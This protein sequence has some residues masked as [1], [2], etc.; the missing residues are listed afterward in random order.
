MTTISHW[1]ELQQKF[2][3]FLGEKGYEATSVNMYKSTVKMLIRYANAH[4]YAEYTP[5]IG[6]EFIKS[7]ERLDYLPF[8]G[9]RSR[10]N[11]IR[12]LDEFLDGGKYTYAHLRMEYN[13]P[14]AFSSE[15]I[16]FL[17]QLQ[18]YGIK[19]RTIA[20]YRAYLIRLFQDF[21]HNGINRWEDVGAKALT[22]AFER[23]TS[24][25]LFAAYSKRL[26]RYLISTGVVKY[27]YS[28]ILPK[29][30]YQKKIPSVYSNS[31]VG[32]LLMSVNRST[33][34]GKRD[35]AIILLA[36]RLGLRAA[37]IR[38]LKFENINFDKAIIEFAQYKTENAQ[39]LILLPEVAEALHDYIDNGRAKS[40]EPYVFLTR[41]K[42]PLSR[43]VPTTIAAKYFKES[44]VEWGDRRHGSHSLRSTFASG[45]VDDGVPFEAVSKILG[46]EDPNALTYYVSFATES[47]RFCA[48]EVP[49]PRGRFAEYL[50]G[51]NGG[52]GNE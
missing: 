22:G 21:I 19:E 48:L 20:Y 50:I 29:V 32:T 51:G 37:D 15:Y 40:D 30:P 47:L 28:G 31:E 2:L 16:G 9:L 13:C 41:R 27:D 10:R 4:Q 8:T 5:Q 36:L 38:L 43:S 46:H 17:Q 6:Q 25:R 33:A 11:V 7:E 24:K 34:M 52:G 44:G 49:A 26:F 45:L 1:R 23:S 14:D 35:Y 3:N 18:E 39:R 12:R 42:L